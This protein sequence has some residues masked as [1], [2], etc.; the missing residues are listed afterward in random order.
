VVCEITRLGLA[1]VPIRHLRGLAG[2]G[3]LVLTTTGSLQPQRPWGS[4]S[5]RVSRWMSIGA[6][7]AAWRRRNAARAGAALG[8]RTAS[9][10]Y[11]SSGMRVT[12]SGKS[13]A[14]AWRLM[15]RELKERGV[16]SHT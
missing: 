6:L 7:T 1:M 10:F 11:R 14:T 2:M 4:S 5:R 8:A 13:R 9:S 3:D 15:G 16:T 12:L